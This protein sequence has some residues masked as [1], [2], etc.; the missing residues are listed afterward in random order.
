IGFSVARRTKEIGIRMALGAKPS[1]VLRSIL[2]EGLVLTS[3][4]AAV[5]LGLAAALARMA[6]S[7]LYGVSPMDAATF[8]G[9][10]VL[11]L[12]IASG[13]CLMPARRAAGLDPLR[14]LRHE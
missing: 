11:L 9:A 4:G 10:A 6:A 12:L 8:V 1:E 13:A 5:G 2:S 7:F 3:I 14:A